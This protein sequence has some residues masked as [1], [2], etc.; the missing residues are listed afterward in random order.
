MVK[1]DPQVSSET[2]TVGVQ[3]LSV[4]LLL[5]VHSLKHCPT[6]PSPGQT[7]FFFFLFLSRNWHTKQKK[8]IQKTLHSV[9]RL[10]GLSSD[11]IIP[12]FA[13][14]HTEKQVFSEQHYKARTRACMGIRL[15]RS[16]MHSKAIKCKHITHSGIVGKGHH[17]YMHITMLTHVVCGFIPLQMLGFPI[18]TYETHSRGHMFNPKVWNKINTDFLI[19]FF[20]FSV[21]HTHIKKFSPKGFTGPEQLHYQ[22][23]FFKEATH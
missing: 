23:L 10:I 18:K 14:L 15:Q 6:A 19:F 12:S 13:V 11:P 3:G 9:A 1:L 7:I 8:F 5:F 20:F 4:L 21:L 17:V 2:T 22:I 16:Y